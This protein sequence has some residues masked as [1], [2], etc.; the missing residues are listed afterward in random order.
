[1]LVAINTDTSGDIRR[2][3]IIPFANLGISHIR[4]IVCFRTFQDLRGEAQ[5]R[6]L[7]STAEH[8]IAETLCQSKKLKKIEGFERF[9]GSPLGELILLGRL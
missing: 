6:F 3:F 1:M 5:S 2:A 4:G 8:C 7:G 9:V